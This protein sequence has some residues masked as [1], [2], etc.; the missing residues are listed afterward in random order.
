M[1]VICPSCDRRLVIDLPTSSRVRRDRARRVRCTHCGSTFA[2][3]PAQVQRGD[4]ATDPVR[5]VRVEGED[6]AVSDLATLQRWILEKRV[7]PQD[8]ASCDGLHWFALDSR[9]EL[10]LFFDAADRMDR[11]PASAQHA[12]MTMSRS[13]AS[14]IFADD[15]PLPEPDPLAGAAAI[16]EGMASDANDMEAIAADE[17]DP[18][19]DMGSLRLDFGQSSPEVRRRDAGEGHPVPPPALLGDEESEPASGPSAPAGSAAIR[20]G[21]LGGGS[22]AERERSVPVVVQTRPADPVSRPLAVDPASNPAVAAADPRS[23]PTSPSRPLGASAASEGAE[24][25]G[26]WEDAGPQNERTEPVSVARAVKVP[27]LVKPP[28]GAGDGPSIARPTAPVPTQPVIPR[29][30][31]S[32]AQ[33]SPGQPTEERPNLTVRP[34]ADPRAGAS[35]WAIALVVA[36]AV[37]V[38]VVAVQQFG[39]ADDDAAGAEPAGDEPSTATRAPEAKPETP[40]PAATPDAASAGGTTTDGVAPATTDAAAATGSTAA[41]TGSTAAAAGSSTAAAGTSAPTAA[42]PTAAAGTSAPTAAAT[43]AP[44][45]TGARPTTSATSTTA[46]AATAGT[47]TRPATTSTSATSSTTGATTRP[48]TT[49]SAATSTG[50]ATRPTSTG[51]SSASTGSASTSSSSGS[52]GASTAGGTTRPT[53]TSTGTAGSSTTSSAPTT[54]I[55]GSSTTTAKPPTTTTTTTSTAKSKPSTSAAWALVQARDYQAAYDMFDTLASGGSAS[56][57][58]GRGYAAEKLGR[59]DAALSDYCRAIASTNNEETLRELSAGL[60]RLGR[61][62]P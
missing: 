10:T 8:A 58:Y 48:A 13:T 61:T 32:A 9:A 19:D 14:D 62:C 1:E 60:R 59:T 27:T 16:A 18:A 50:A 36:S 22:A 11:G 56:A 46:Q 30:P 5:W 26:G 24:V 17:G 54:V 25:A 2:F 15:A 53:S 51:T 55:S 35:P 7:L 4:P 44:T 41:A 20:V 43:P 49:S 47:S 52:S 38:I 31:P 40:S 57:V 29:G 37:F 39:G 23:A 12:M 3:N 34:E 21:V 45:S 6:F 42:A 33:F 28:G